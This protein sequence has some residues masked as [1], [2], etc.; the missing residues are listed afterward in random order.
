MSKT[1]IEALNQP[2]EI[3]MEVTGILIDGSIT[4]AVDLP[5]RAEYAFTL[6]TPVG[7]SPPFYLLNQEGVYFWYVHFHGIDFTTA[8]NNVEVGFTRTW[9][10]IHQL[11]LRDAVS[12]AAAGCIHPQMKPGDIVIMDDF[13]DFATHRPRSILTEIWERPPWIGAQYVPPLCPELT[14]ILRSVSSER[15][16]QG[17]VFPSGTLGHFEG[18]RFESPGEIRMAKHV[19]ADM[20]AQ[21]QGTEAI[22]ARELG[23]HYC[24]LNYITNY[25]AGLSPSSPSWVNE[26]QA[27]RG[28]AQCTEILLA[29]MVRAAKRNPVCSACPRPHNE[30]SLPNVEQKPTYR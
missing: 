7:E 8:S 24:A 3:E 22:Y 4:Y 13:I 19:G 23:I 26:D 14:D 12:G 25:A 5:A 29:T 2:P 11:G 18:H 16:T 10:V 17:N 20:V 15:Y 9:Y 21:S 27:K 6:P 28:Y 30:S 1:I